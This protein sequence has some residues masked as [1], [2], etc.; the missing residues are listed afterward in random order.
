MGST[1]LQGMPWNSIYL[2]PV[3]LSRMRSENGRSK[4]KAAPSIHHKSPLH[5]NWRNNFYLFVSL[6]LISSVSVSSASSSK[7]ERS[8]EARR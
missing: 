7:E 5:L 2:A 6:A 3:C 4:L 8:Q 1:G